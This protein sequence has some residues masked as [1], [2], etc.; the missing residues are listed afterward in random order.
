MKRKRKLLLLNSSNY[1]PAL[2]YPYAF[3]QVTEIADRFN[4]ETY[5]QDMI[6]IAEQNWSIFLRET[7]NSLQPDMILISL[8]NIGLFSIEDYQAWRRKGTEEAEEERNKDIKDLYLPIITTKR[9][10]KI[11]RKITKI[12]I[13]LGGFGYSLLP[14]RLYTF[15][16]PNFGVVG[17]PDHFFENFEDILGE[18]NLRNVSNLVF[19]LSGQVIQNARV[20][21]PPSHRKEYTPELIKDRFQFLEEY[22]RKNISFMDDAI[23]I[24]VVRGCTKNCIFCSEP[25]VKG[26][27]L[28]YRDLKIIRSEIELLGQY[29]LNK[30]MFI[31]SEI[32]SGDNIYFLKLTEVVTELNEGRKF[33]K[34][35]KWSTFYLMKHLSEGDLQK[36]LLSG[37]VRGADDIISLDD[38]DL[39]RNKT[40]VSSEDILTHFEN[41]IKAKVSL[42]DPKANWMKGKNNEEITSRSKVIA[43]F[44]TNINVFL[45][46]IYSSPSVIQKTIRKMKK[47]APNFKSCYINQGYRVMEYINIPAD[48]LDFVWTI[49][50][51]GQEISYDEMYPSF[52]YP[53]DLLRY[54]QDDR[55]LVSFFKLV[56]DTYLSSKYKEGLKWNL[57]LTEQLKQSQ[58]EAWLVEMTNRQYGSIFGEKKNSLKVKEWT[59]D[60]ILKEIYSKDNTSSLLT[61]DNILQIIMSLFDTDKELIDSTLMFLDLP[62]PIR[63]TLTLTPYTITHHLFSK[64]LD[65]DQMLSDLRK[66][67]GKDPKVTFFIDFLLYN[68]NIPFEK[69][70]RIFFTSLDDEEH[71]LIR[72]KQ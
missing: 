58:L 62:H 57:L 63:E 17:G 64:Y 49:G 9:L 60:R 8:R 40:P 23:P 69:D 6:R 7:I 41:S 65:R 68:F 53:P 4:I 30:I 39:E 19:K 50:E 22:S 48:Y 55:R 51:K 59:K 43:Q 54:F 2:I 32:N 66:Q 42:L 10:I 45:G 29:N 34:K 28:R 1:L 20:F 3:V 33:D 16:Q 26:K 36:I 15:L 52:T 56:G 37:F 47:F 46:N 67:F 25:H 11:L 27:K 72:G 12:P 5:S 24:E 35:I 61:N 38:E 21:F 31:C 44:M 13:T 14:I 71:E 18:E 70:I